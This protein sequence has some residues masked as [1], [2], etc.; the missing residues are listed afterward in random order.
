MSERDRFVAGVPCWVDTWQQDIAAAARFYG[1]LFGWTV[2]ETTPP[3]SERRYLMCRLR[4]RDVA[5]IG[6]PIPAQ[7][8]PTPVWS[9]YV[10]VESAEDTVARARA[11]G[12]AV[13]VE[14]GESMDGGRLAFIS[15]PGGAAIGV[16]EQAEHGGAQLVNEPSAWAMSILHTREP[17]A[18]RDFYGALFGWETEPFATGAGDAEV[19][20]FR[21][22]GYVG[23]EP[24]QPVPRDVVAVMVEMD[25][26]GF[27]AIVPPHW[28]VD[29]RIA[30][31]DAAF[32]KATELGGMV[33]MPPTDTPAFR[34]A[35]LADPAG[36]P[37][38]LSQLRLPPG[39]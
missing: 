12:G 18:S 37:F 7:A 22:P 17:D 30:D 16:W 27:P 15:D 26:H 4:G 2:E 24:E 28:G 14:P 10:A 32:A 29:F 39:A 33:Y 19:E 6:S 23:G 21:R 25:S 1:E 9:S 5:G 35:A 8:P 31:V 36:A 20:L 3:G 34:Q 38:I 13:V 11:A